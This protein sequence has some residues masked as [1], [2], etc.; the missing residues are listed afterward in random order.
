MKMGVI[1]A[2]LVVGACLQAMG[3]EGN[4][5]QAGS[6]LAQ[7]LTNG[8]VDP[9]AAA[10][11]RDEE[12]L[13]ASKKAS[14]VKSG[15]ETYVGLCQ[16]CHA[17]PKAKGDSPS[18]LFDSKWFHGSRPHEIERT[19]LQGVLEKNMPGWGAVLPPEDTT[20]VTAYLLSQQKS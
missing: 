17:D 10:A 20:A 12:L 3:I 13:A 4:R 18:N 9:A 16:T 15:K 8:D 14:I 1:G 6:Y 7:P 2:L 5:L 19:I 11:K